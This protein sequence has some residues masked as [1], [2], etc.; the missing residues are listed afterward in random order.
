MKDRELVK[1]ATSFRRGLLGKKSS[2]MMCAVVSWPLASLLRGL[3]GIDCECVESDLG[4]CNHIWIKLPDGRALDAT[5]D[6]FNHL[7]S[8]QNPTVYLGPPLEIHHA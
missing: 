2:W 5:A 7:S 6:Q 8:T 1:I 4:F 3:Y